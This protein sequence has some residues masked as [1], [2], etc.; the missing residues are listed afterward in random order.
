MTPELLPPAIAAE[1]DAGRKASNLAFTLT[2]LP[3]ERR[4]D[5]LT[6]YRFC[7][8]LDDIAD[9]PALTTTERERALDAW[10]SALAGTLPP[11]MDA[12]VTRYA[13]D[14]AHLRAILTGVR[15]DLTTH[16]YATFAEARIYCWHVASAVGLVSIRIFGCRAPESPAYAEALGLALQ[17]T[18][19]L[20]DVGE[21]AA[22]G[23]IYLPQDE[24]ARFNVDPDALLA[25]RPTGDFAGLMAF[26]GERAEELFRAAVPPVADRV[27]LRP[28]AIMH[29]LYH[30]L[31]AQ[32]RADGYRVLEKRYRLTRVEKLLLAARTALGW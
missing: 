20:R 4:R 12:L 31:L 5:A 18:N 14:R 28:A 26:Q 13:I 9:S 30:R 8:I 17:W 29:R 32:M 23:R 2:A 24:L 6:F 3:A 1:I 22:N 19:I 11:E 21:D 15:S 25:G 10:E 27:P 16:R 7:R